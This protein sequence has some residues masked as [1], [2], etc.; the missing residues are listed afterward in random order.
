MLAMMGERTVMQ[1]ALFYGFS[2]ERHVPS[3]H[4]LRSI[5]RFVDLSGVRAH[6]EPYYSM[7]G[8]PSIDPELMLRML[9]V[10]YCFGVRSERRLCDEIHLNLAY[11][12]F[13]R[14]GL[15]GNVPDHSTFSKNRH[16]RF[17]DSDLL[18]QVF[19]SVV[20]RCM[21]E[22]LVGGEGF[23]VDASVIA[24]DAHRQR[25]VAGTSD[26]NSTSNRAVME[27]LAVLNDAAFGGA[28]PVEPKFVSP[29]DPAARW[30]A[31]SGGPAF[32]AYADNYLID[33]KHAVIMDVE[34]TTAVRQAEVTAAKTMITRTAD[35]FDAR[36][37]RLASDTGYGS[38]EMLAWL[39][40][41][42]GIEPHIPVFD[43][44]G[45]T[46]GSLSRDAFN[47]DQVAD[48]Y[49]CP[50]GKTMTTTGTLVND[51]ATL[52]YRA[53]KH[54]CDACDL[55]PRCCPNTP[56]RKVPRSI[57]EAAR[58]RA[59][60]IAK[61]DAYVTSRRERKKVEMLFA[62]LKR[63]LKLDRLRLRGPC[64]ARDE[65]LLAATAQNLRKMAKLIPMMQPIPA[66]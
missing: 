20:A 63:I 31:A 44:S 56:V 14:L 23:A 66:M 34:A 45:R 53:S 13:C 51:E 58:D 26:L 7:I 30:T 4:M 41:E 33:L 5:D 11:R 32:Y 12:W 25:G 47:Y 46:D 55:K 35:R 22:G 43:K 57:H 8:R 49:V 40:D 39:V 65:F 27:Y 38:A 15:E 3:D 60:D 61:T 54:D 48:V 62:H 36:P 29:T 6:L 10:G 17:R 52:I 37:T 28:T 42:R 19:E 9:I 24:A 2:L 59:R 1:E 64:G 16:G 18:R 21:E 50:G